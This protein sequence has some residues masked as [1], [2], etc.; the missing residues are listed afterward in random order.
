M[1]V[2]RKKWLFGGIALALI[3]LIVATR[4]GARLPGISQDNR[5]SAHQRITTPA[6][7]QPFDDRLSLSMPVAFGPSTDIPLE[8]FPLEIRE[9]V[10]KM[11]QRSAYFNGIY[12]VVMKLTNARG[13]K[14]GV[15]ENLHNLFFRSAN[16]PSPNMP[17]INSTYVN[18]V[19]ES[20]AI[21]FP[22]VF[23]NSR[24]QMTAVVIKSGTEEALWLI[25][26]WGRGESADLAEKTARGFAFR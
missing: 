7:M 26:A 14:A 13:I 20:G 15:E 25:S 5:E 11:T 6:T 8:K 2:T 21:R 4:Y 1:K 17:K 22:A 18:G 3:I 12:I 24:G 19:Y 10:Q 9:K 16:P 23:G